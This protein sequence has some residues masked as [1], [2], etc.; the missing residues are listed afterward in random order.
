M[1]SSNK[2]E[3]LLQYKSNSLYS[4]IV[5]MKHF[6]N[7]TSRVINKLHIVQI[8]KQPNKYYI[9]ISKNESYAFFAFG[10]GFLDSYDNVIEICEKKNKQDYDKITS[11]IENMDDK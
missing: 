9:H 11:E 2:V 10:S 5:E 7:L 1:F 4:S 3:K 8:V 6:I